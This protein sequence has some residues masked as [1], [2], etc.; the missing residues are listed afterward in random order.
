MLS[1][2]NL[3]EIEF[4]HYTSLSA[5]APSTSRRSRIVELLLG[6]LVVFVTLF[7]SCYSFF[8]NPV[9]NI[10][11]KSAQVSLCNEVG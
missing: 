11:K 2:V 10:L 6:D 7:L 9:G 8:R 3:S 1:K 4:S 5:I